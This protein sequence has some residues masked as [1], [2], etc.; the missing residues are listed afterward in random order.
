[1]TEP[2]PE[3]I[4]LATR[5]SQL[6]LAQSGMLARQ[7]EVARPGARCE[8]IEVVTSGDRIQDRAL[9]E[10]GGKALFTKEIEEALLDG[11][12]DI[13][14]HSLKDVAT[15]QPPGLA[16]IAIPEREDPADALICRVRGATLATLP[17]GA[18]VGTGSLRRGGLVLWQRP[19]L[20]VVPIRGNVG[21][22]LGRLEGDDPLDAVILA[23][24]G[25]R[26]LG[27]EHVARTRLDPTRFVPAAGQG[28]LAI[29]AA[30]HRA[31]LRW[32]TTAVDH[33]PTR[34][35][36]AAERAFLARVEGSCRVPVA[37]Y[38]CQADG[39]WVL[40]GC[41]ASDA[42]DVVQVTLDRPGVWDEAEAHAWGDELANR[43]LLAGGAGIARH[44]LG[45]AAPAGGEGEGGRST[46]DADVEG[47][48]RAP[49]PGTVYLVGGGPGDLGLI[50]VRGRELLAGADA[51]VYDSLA[52]PELIAAIGEQA[53]RHYVGKRAGEHASTQ[54][55]IGD[56][57]IALAGRYDTVVRLKGGDPFIFGRGGEEAERLVEAG[58]PFEVVPGVT[59]AIAAPAF[60]GVPLTHRGHSSSVV[61]ITGHSAPDAVVDWAS[62]ARQDTIVVLMGVARAADNF[63]ALMA[64]GRPADDPVL[65]V[66]WASFP[67]QRV[68][69]TTLREASA[70]ASAAGL[71]SPA[72]FVVGAVAALHDRLHW[73]RQRPLFGRKVLVTRSRQQASRLATRLFQ[74]GAVPVELPAIA[75]H[76]VGGAER[77]RLDDALA[78]LSDYD[79]VVFT[80]HNGVRHAMEA[81]Y[82]RTGAAATRDARAFA[83]TRLATIGTVTRETLAEYGLQADLV[84]ERFDA[85]GLLEAIGPETRANGRVLVLRAREARPVL[86][87]GLRERGVTVDDV[88][89]YYTDEPAGLE[90]RVADVLRG[91]LDLITF[92]SSKTVTN[93][94]RAAGPHADALRRVPAACIGPVTRRAAT[95]AGFEVVVQPERFTVDAL[96]AAVA[97]WAELEPSPESAPNSDDAS[98]QAAETPRGAP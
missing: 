23:E 83:G 7:L 57:L 74:A 17:A 81:L 60:A 71:E 26:R 22:R 39:R 27:F 37:A 85:E 28:A 76:S 1:M 84:P 78:R 47:G 87:E 9:R 4:R 82:A 53:E 98:A 6:A 68:V 86:I 32:I 79:W 16:L 55:E 94:V 75:I 3:I 14:V 48:E 44:F 30:E 96:V 41:I 31:D 91:G 80:S 34:L 13:A 62:V 52:N 29:Q 10:V 69:R 66:E 89:T 65:A 50:T 18:R 43:V 70:A 19:D 72:V 64:A 21:T 63:A 2:A 11:R 73:F 90:Q 93:L 15:E 54:D 40:T 42:G 8:L 12:A 67:R 92:A 46:Y 58:V 51:V 25:L 45:G 36:A 35:A 88:A 20:T 61:F 38:L 33:G 24:A 95:R 49:G 59:S 56:L 5:R 77:A 97:R